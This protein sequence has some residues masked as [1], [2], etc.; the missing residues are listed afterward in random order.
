MWFYCAEVIWESSYYL[1]AAQLEV[2]RDN[3]LQ[4]ELASHPGQAVERVLTG[5]LEALHRDDA[6]DKIREGALG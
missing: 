5:F 4:E 3:L 2:E 1:I 6:F